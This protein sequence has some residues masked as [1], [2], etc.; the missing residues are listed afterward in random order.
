LT[1]KNWAGQEQS[2]NYG[3]LILHVLNHATHHRGMVALYLDMLGVEN[4][5]S[6]LTEIL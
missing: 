3:G 4:D 2:K 5:F 1:Y 6:N